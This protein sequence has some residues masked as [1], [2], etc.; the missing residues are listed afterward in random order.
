MEGPRDYTYGVLSGFSP[1]GCILPGV[2]APLSNMSDVLF[3]VSTSNNLSI[4]TGLA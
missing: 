1:V 2:S 4:I 3:A